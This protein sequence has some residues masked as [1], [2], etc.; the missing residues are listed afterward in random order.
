MIRLPSRIAL[1]VACAAHWSAAAITA[2][3]V[4]AEVPAYERLRKTGTPLQPSEAGALL[5][6]ELSCAACHEPASASV[7]APAK[8]LRW[9]AGPDL[10]AAGDRLRATWLRQY[11]MD[12]ATVKPGTTMPDLLSGMNASQRA[13]MVEDLTHY[14]MG[15]RP[16]QRRNVKPVVG[17][18]K[19]GKAVFESVGCVACHST[20][21]PSNLGEKYAPGELAKFLMNPLAV[22]PSGRMPDQRLGKKDA[23]HL[24]AYLAPT[25]LPAEPPFEQDAEQAQRGRK[26]YHSLGCVSCHGKPAEDRP[27]P[28][29]AN[30]HQGCLAPAGT[31]TT[32]VPQYALSEE[33]REA[34]RTSI[35]ASRTASAEQDPKSA[36][37]HLLLQRNCIACHTR[38]GQGGPTPEV[39]AHFHSTKDDLGDLGRLPPPLDGVGRKFQRTALESVLR[40][41]D[42]VRTYMRVKMPDFGEDLSKY[43]PDLLA[44]ADAQAEETPYALPKVKNPDLTGRAEWGRELVGTGGYACIVCHDING[45][46]SL[47][48]GAYDLAQMPKRLRPEWMR[49]F[50]LN[51]AGFATGT[52]MPPFWPQGKPMNPALAGGTAE[53]QIDSIRR[54]LLEVDESLPP[55]G[56]A[57]RA[58]LLLTP[59]LKPLV[60]RT[61]LKG[62]GTHAIAV[63][64]PGGISAA[65]DALQVRW[66]M[67]WRGKFLDADGTWNQ[68]Y[69]KMEQPLGDSLVRLEETGHLILPGQPAEKAVFRGYHLTPEGVPV[70]EYTLGPL[71]IEDR[72]EPRPS[73]GLVRRLEV[74]GPTPPVPVQF[75]ASPPTGVELKSGSD[76]LEINPVTLT[77]HDGKATFTEEI[78]W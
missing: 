67:A 14:L 50:L 66:S 77:F 73:G 35:T 15:L 57:D 47:G 40:G 4:C 43:L 1:I 56:M 24:A 7:S 21:L 16:K 72:L 33:Q 6:S 64:F 2:A 48:I 37:R 9:K 20:T 34:L 39:A 44:K 74:R 38:D 26:A 78:T 63:G 62:T 12:P 58:T 18:S 23:A 46:P 13:G 54:Y 70:F 61:F 30:L 10:S 27:V 68:R 71:Q 60:F 25:P 51:P 5:Y 69:V 59:E 41:R 3:E 53:R 49:D 29:L 75:R 65:F 42:L 31:Q 17:S 76:S 11:L 36:I 45:Q 52:R 8:S 28:P 55:P 19:T 32:G 22:R